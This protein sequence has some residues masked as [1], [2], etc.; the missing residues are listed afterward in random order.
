MANLITKSVSL[1]ANSLVDAIGDAMEKSGPSNEERLFFENEIAKASLQHEIEISVLGLE[2]D[3][4]TQESREKA[5]GHQTQIQ[6]NENANWLAKNVHSILAIGIIGLTFFIYAWIIGIG[7]GLEKLKDSGMKD[8][9]IY[10]LG[11]LTTI[12]T[13]VAAYFFGSSQG[14]SDKNKV[15]SKIG[16]YN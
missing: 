11:A 16:N 1:N 4:Q 14:S 9:I 10:I 6:E 15:L 12:S 5:M 7:D 2:K 13:Q 3:K 8:I